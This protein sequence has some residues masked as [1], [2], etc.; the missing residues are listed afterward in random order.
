MNIPNYKS[1]ACLM[2]A[3]AL[4]TGAQAAKFSDYELKTAVFREFNDDSN[5]ETAVDSVGGVVGTL[6]G[7]EDESAMAV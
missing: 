6:Q 1:F 3:L 4:S 2:A 5:P 7:T